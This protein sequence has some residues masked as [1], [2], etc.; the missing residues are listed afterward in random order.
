M[1]LAPPRAC[2]TCGRAACTLHR[3][4]AWQP[5][6]PVGRM[7]GRRL[8]RARR[9]LF[10]TSPLCVACLAAG[11]IVPAAVRDHVVALAHGGSDDPQ[12]TQALCWACNE[13]KR[14]AEARTGQ[15]RNRRGAV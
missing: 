5:T 7:R 10:E 4:P 12:N 1:P 9:D 13:A 6:V 3:R 2:A 11:R 8:Q 14:Q 15:M